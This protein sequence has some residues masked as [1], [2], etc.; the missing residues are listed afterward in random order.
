MDNSAFIVQDLISAQTDL[1]LFTYV[2]YVKLF[3]QFQHS[4]LFSTSDSISSTRSP[5]PYRST[6]LLVDGFKNETWL[7]LH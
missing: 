1:L 4:N 6:H 5:L 3:R 7:F 2:I